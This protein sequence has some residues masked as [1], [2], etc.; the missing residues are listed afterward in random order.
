MAKSKSSKQPIPIGR[1]QHVGPGV[2]AAAT[3]SGTPQTL[4]ADQEAHPLDVAIT[5]DALIN[6]VAAEL[7]VKSAQLKQANMLFR[8]YKDNAE[9][10]VADYEAVIAKLEAK[11]AHYEPAPEKPTEETLA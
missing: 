10:V 5:P 7:G 1:P 6:G 3:M 4:P 2:Q 9:K 11:L 8:A